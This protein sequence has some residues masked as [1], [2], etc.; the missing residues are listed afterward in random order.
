M[1]ANHTIWT[2]LTLVAL[3]LTPRV[4]ADPIVNVPAYPRGGGPASLA[5]EPV[6]PAGTEL[7][8]RM[9]NDIGTDRA[10]RN[11]DRFTATLETQVLG[12]RGDVILPRGAIIEG[13]VR[14]MHRGMREA[15]LA[16]TVEGV[17]IGSTFV[18]ISADIVHSQNETWRSG[19]RLLEQVRLN[20]GAQIVVRLTGPVSVAAI[21][22]ALGASAVGG[23]PR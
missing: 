6:I 18:P 9:N 17:R 8:A 1:H 7:Y 23:G 10:A 13:S 20:T 5:N 22:R 15:Q 12:R 4:H 11:T 2:S 16:L 3:S 19:P 14:A 21:Q